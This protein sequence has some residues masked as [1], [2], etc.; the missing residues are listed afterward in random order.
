MDFVNTYLQRI[1][2]NL[3]HG[4]QRREGSAQS[5]VYA[6]VYPDLKR[7]WGIDIS[8][9][10][11]IVNL[12]VTQEKGA[13]FVFIKAMDG[14]LPSKYFPENRQASIEAGLLH[15]PYAWLYRD[16]NVSC[17][18]QARAYTELIKKYPCDLPPVID[19][20]WTKWQGKPS[21]PDYKDLDKWVTEF[22][23][24]GNRKPILYTAAGFA[25]TLGR[26]PVNL[27]EKFEGLWVANFGVNNPQ[28]PLG[29]SSH[30]FHQFTDLGDAQSLAPG[31]R[32]KLELDL[33]YWN[34]SKQ[35]LFDLASRVVPEEPPPAETKQR[36]VVIKGDF[37]IIEMK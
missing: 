18:A 22:L 9:W 24:L 15:A 30:L 2:N 26:I 7:V 28:I 27:K 8:S 4:E 10:D 23:K 29:F 11:G 35:S 21:N 32:N 14:T 1:Q 19:F 5:A 3:L 25:N 12:K 33:N 13:Q 16:V 6:L 37:E 17:A 36:T 31:N 20:E 34:G